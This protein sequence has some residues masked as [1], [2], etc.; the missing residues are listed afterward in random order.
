MGRV[1]IFLH[2]MTNSLVPTEGPTQAIQDY[3]PHATRFA[4]TLVLLLR[5]L[6]I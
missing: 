1:Q 6:Y 3:I 4:L 2:I 5:N